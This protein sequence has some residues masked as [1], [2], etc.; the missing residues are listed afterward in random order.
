MLVPIACWPDPAGGLRAAVP[1]LGAGQYAAASEQALL[2]MV[3]LA[4][5]DAL[6]RRLLDGESLPDTRAGVPPEGYAAPQ[7]LRWLT[8]HINLDHLR[9][10]A[11]HQ[12][13]RS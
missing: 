11:R 10:L 12:R 7:R 3:R 13:G 6:T 4:I 1:D 9:A 5:E 2:P 8:I